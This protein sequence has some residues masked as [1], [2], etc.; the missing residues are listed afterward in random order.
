MLKSQRSANRLNSMILGHL[1]GEGS[2]AKRFAELVILV[3][4]YETSPTFCVVVLQKLGDVG[5]A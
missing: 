5:L 1:L 3:L 2:E 4:V